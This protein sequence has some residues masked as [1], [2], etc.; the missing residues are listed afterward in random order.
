MGQLLWMK[1]D[2]FNEDIALRPAKAG[3]T[4]LDISINAKDG[5]IVIA[6][7][8]FKSIPTGIRVK[9]PDGHWGLLKA[10]SSAHFKKR[11]LVIDGVIDEGY[12]GPLF[13]MVH[14]PGIDP[15]SVYHL[16]RIAQLIIIR[17]AV[18]EI[19][20]VDELPNTERGTAGFGSSGGITET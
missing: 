8:E 14:N 12:T 17:C 18:P 2:G 9:I 6:P 20:L 5:P 15:V 3:D 10:R 16:E 1:E 19:I 7:H 11:L 4:G 13:C